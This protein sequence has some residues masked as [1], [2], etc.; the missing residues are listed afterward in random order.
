MMTEE[1]KLNTKIYCSSRRL[2]VCHQYSRD[3]AVKFS[4]SRII[5]YTPIAIFFGRNEINSLYSRNKNKM[6][7]RANE[8]RSCACK[9]SSITIMSRSSSTTITCQAPLIH[10]LCRVCIIAIIVFPIIGSLGALNDKFHLLL[11]LHAILSVPAMRCSKKYEISLP[12]NSIGS[13]TYYCTV[14]SGQAR[15]KK[16]IQVKTVPTFDAAAVLNVSTTITM[17]NFLSN[18]RAQ[19]VK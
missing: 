7:I 2:L 15:A 4:C 9:Y 11:P 5:F 18:R 14:Y 16:R 1:V 6:K 17:L 10:T 8:S 19:S 12:L 3:H 13:D